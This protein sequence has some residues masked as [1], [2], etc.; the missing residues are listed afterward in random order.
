MGLRVALVRSG[1]PPTGLLALV[2]CSLL[3]RKDYL[4]LAPLGACFLGVRT[5]FKLGPY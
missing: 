1:S 2:I 4:G 5:V 3:F